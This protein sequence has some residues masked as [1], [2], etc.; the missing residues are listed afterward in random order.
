MALR[1]RGQHRAMDRF[2]ARAPAQ[3]ARERL[4]HALERRLA[5]ALDEPVR[6]EDH[7]RRADAALG[8]HLAH[9]R[10][11]ERVV[12]G[13]SFDRRDLAALR[14]RARHEAGDDR[15]TVHEHGA[16]AALAL[17]AALLRAGEA[18]VL[19]KDIQEPLQGVRVQLARAAV[20]LELHAALPFCETPS[21]GATASVSGVAGIA[22]TSRP[23]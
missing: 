20:E 22:R 11:L 12:A 2:V 6:G 16:R 1:V 13:E 9:H 3:V 21:R 10:A 15:L 17:A 7:A 18:A 5:R 23:A 14:L 8:T 19:S 4:A